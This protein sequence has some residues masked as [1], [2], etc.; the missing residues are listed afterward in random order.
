M[1]LGTCHPQ[2]LNFSQK[3]RINKEEIVKVFVT[4]GVKWDSFN[5]S[6][7]QIL[8]AKCNSYFITILGPPL[9]TA[10]NTFFWE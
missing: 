10:I 3:V 7:L 9:L 2:T 4:T 6:I 5:V 1:P 8:C